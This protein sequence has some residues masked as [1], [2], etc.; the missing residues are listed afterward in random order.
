M[1]QQE[2]NNFEK[3]ND[4]FIASFFFLQELANLL[5][6]KRPR[7]ILEVGVG[8]GTIPYSVRQFKDKF[9]YVGTETLDL[10]IDRLKI[11]APFVR[12]FKDVSEVSG[13]FDLI[14]VDGRDKNTN[15]LPS[16]LN[17]K[18]L[19]LVENDRRGQVEIIKNSTN[20]EHVNYR[21]RPFSFYKQAGYTAMYFEPGMK[22]YFIYAYFA[23][24]YWVK[25]HIAFALGP[26]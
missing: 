23:S 25:S 19:I 2:Y 14:I 17:E 24:L 3:L 16:M 7:R 10:C 12:L 8:M 9:E 20:R 26:L 1:N 6:A 21:K 13:K 11:N 18:G 4:G 15:N 5:Q 22:E